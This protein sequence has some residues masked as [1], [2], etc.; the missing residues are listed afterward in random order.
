[1]SDGSGS[2]EWT[3]APIGPPH[4]PGVAGRVV[5]ATLSAAAG[6]I[7]LAM[8]PSH[9]GSS[10]IEGV[11]FAIAGWLQIVVALL[12]VT[13]PSRALLR[14][15]MLVNCAFI[16]IWAIS[17]T[18]GLPF[19]EHSGHPHD[20]AFVDLTCV[21]LEAALIVVTGAL[22]Q[23]PELGRELTRR[24]LAAGAVVP[25][26]FVGL[27]TAAIASPSARD[28]ADSAHGA[29]DAA[30]AA[31]ALHDH[32]VG[33]AAAAASRRDDKGLSKLDNGHQHGS[34]EVK[35]D[36][37]TQ[38]ALTQQLNQLHRLVEK[39][40]TVAAAEAAGY[41]RAGPFSPGLG[42]HYGGF[43]NRNMADDMIQ[44]VD[45]PMIPML[46]FDGTEPNSPL[47]GFMFLSFK[48]VGQPPE[49]F[50]GPNDHWHYHTNTCVVYRNGV[51]E[52]PLGADRDVSLAECRAVG[53]NL[54]RTT[55]Y[56]VHVWTV[57]GYESPRG[58]FSEINPKITCPDGTYYK[59]PTKQVGF[60]VT[61]CRNARA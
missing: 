25:L 18:W 11:G 49:G 48:G 29:H 6:G 47:A 32:G 41:R 38:A 43:G 56:M 37:A 52:A 16:G 58:V 2:T 30:R 55:T 53:G 3:A 5:V 19:G 24:A 1:M 59:V 23:R 61:T 10:T 4:E 34:G 54:I 31:T 9:M 20:A 57:P 15:A 12:F 21:G 60:A 27:A 40:P 35:L 39:Y 14:F 45:G 7:H 50:I 8:V 26:A 17:R 22:L 51:I 36:P 13:R 44:G 46:V 33:T 28:H 42:T